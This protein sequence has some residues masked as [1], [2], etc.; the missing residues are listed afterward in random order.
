MTPFLQ[1][2]AS[3]WNGMD[4]TARTFAIAL[5]V[6]WVILQW[7][8]MIAFLSKEDQATVSGIAYWVW[9][10]AVTFVALHLGS[11]RKDQPK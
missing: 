7:P 3:R 1:F 8:W 6:S 4:N 10:G 11:K 2:F 5:P 9:H